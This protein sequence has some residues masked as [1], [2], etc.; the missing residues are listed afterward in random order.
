VKLSAG[1]VIRGRILKVTHGA[2]DSEIS[3]ELA[4]GDRIVALATRQSAEKLDL[5][6]GSEAFAVIKATNVMI[7]VD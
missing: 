5:V 3:L 6:E 4:G 2:V 1:N 7:A